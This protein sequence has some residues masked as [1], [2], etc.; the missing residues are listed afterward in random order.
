MIFNCRWLRRF[1]QRMSGRKVLLLL[2]NAPCHIIEG[3]ELKNTQVKFL[4]PNYT[5]RIQPC[6]AGI[7]ASF[8]KHY[9]RRFVHHLLE[10]F[11]DNELVTKLNVLE[12]IQFAKSAWRDDVTINTIANCWKHTGIIDFDNNEETEQEGNETIADIEKNITALRS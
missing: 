3:V 2:D 5:S 1:D 11:E 6:D 12:A 10:K 9:R 7:I 8:K 4:P